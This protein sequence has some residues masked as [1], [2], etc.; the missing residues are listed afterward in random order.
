MRIVKNNCWSCSAQWDNR[1]KIRSRLVKRIYTFLYIAVYTLFFRGR[2]QYI[3]A[4]AAEIAPRTPSTAQER[5]SSQG[6]H[7]RTSIP[8]KIFKRFTAHGHKH[9]HLIYSFL[10]GGCANS[11][12]KPEVRYR[13]IRGFIKREIRTKKRKT[14]P[15]NP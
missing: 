9:T 5:E 4:A 8:Y 2:T 1:R 7:I 11:P 6:P 10:G 15:A 14:E 3:V 12:Q 13:K